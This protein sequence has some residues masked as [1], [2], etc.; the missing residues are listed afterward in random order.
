MVE[1]HFPDSFLK[2]KLQE[3]LEAIGA[4]RLVMCGMMSHMCIDT[5]V[6]SA[7]ARE[8]ETILLHDA[9][10]TKDLPWENATVPAETV[11]KAFMASLHGSFARVICTADLPGVLA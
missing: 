4:K 6:R 3:H 2:T 10:A 8:Y 11:H 1:K 5:T 9:C 7:K